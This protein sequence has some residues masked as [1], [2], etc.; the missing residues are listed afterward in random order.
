[1]ELSKKDIDF[2]VSILK[3]YI[4]TSLATITNRGRIKVHHFEE[5][6]MRT[7]NGGLPLDQ[8]LFRTYLQTCGKVNVWIDSDKTGELPTDGDQ[9]VL[10]FLWM[11]GSYVMYIYTDMYVLITTTTQIDDLNV[12]GATT[13]SSQKIVSLI[14]TTCLGMSYSNQ[15]S[16]LQS[17]NAQGAI[18]EL[19]FLIDAIK[20]TGSG[21]LG[22]P[23]YLT[24]Q[25]SDIEG[26]KKLSYEP[27][28]NPKTLDIPVTNEEVLVGTFLFDDPIDVSFIGSGNWI[29]SMFAKVSSS[30]GDSRLRTQFFFRKVSAAEGE[31]IE[32]DLVS[33]STRE[34]DNTNYAIV[35][36]E[37][38]STTLITPP[39]SR[40]G[41]RLYASTTAASEKIV[42][43]QLGNGFPTYVTTPLSIR[44][45]Q[46]RDKNGN[47]NFLHITQAEKNDFGIKAY[48]Y[49]RVNVAPTI[50]LKLAT[51]TAIIETLTNANTF[52]ITLP[53]PRLN[54]VNESIITFKIGSTVPNITLPANLKWYT[55]EIVLGKNSTRTLV[56][57]QKTFDGVNFE[58]WVSCDKNV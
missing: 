16:G 35:P 42:S 19:K 11:D 13:Y 10:Y 56:F 5:Q 53:T 27:D 40:I 45:D 22:A 7:V 32:E 28:A 23:L 34:I 9:D 49:E 55:D 52:A 43:V 51:Q 26:Y 47:P 50:A 8:S 31:E 44:H 17:T 15:I 41:I 12:S 4:D 29:L 3:K 14:V 21:R 58:T 24:D 36:G 54:K 25:D 20:Q 1:M 46:T 18:D 57:E 2:L 6:Y 37:S 48:A 30:V 38:A 39:T 33:V